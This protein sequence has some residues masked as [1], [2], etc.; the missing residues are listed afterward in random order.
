MSIEQKTV[1]LNSIDEDSGFIYTNANCAV[2][3]CLDPDYAIQ[4][5]RQFKNRIASVGN[6]KYVGFDLEFLPIK[7][8][9]ALTLISMASNS[10]CVLLTFNCLTDDVLDVLRSILASPGV[11]KM[12]F[13]ISADAVKMSNICQIINPLDLCAIATIIHPKIISMNDVSKHYFDVGKSEPSSIRTSKGLKYAIRDALLSYYCGLMMLQNS[14][15]FNIHSQLNLWLKTLDEIVLPEIDEL[16]IFSPEGVVSFTDMHRAAEESVI[17]HMSRKPVNKDV[18]CSPWSKRSYVGDITNV[19]LVHY[20]AAGFLFVKVIN[21][22]VFFGTWLNTKT[23]LIEL[24]CGKREEVDQSAP[25]ATAIRETMEEMKINAT[26]ENVNIITKIW[27]SSSRCILYV[28]TVDVEL[29]KRILWTNEYG[30]SIRDYHKTLMILGTSFG[31]KKL[32]K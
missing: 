3:V 22:K 24:P 2:A 27:H 20:A 31:I 16:K 15:Y 26:S 11:V 32:I 9:H 6:F 21:K 12:G 14:D 7:N 5:L 17:K 1:F 23:G 28:A 29:D 30:S 10:Q 18:Q 13:G 25:L 19:D 4:Q 8:G